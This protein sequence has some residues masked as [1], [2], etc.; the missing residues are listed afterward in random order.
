MEDEAKVRLL[1]SDTSPAPDQV[2]SGEEIAGFLELGE[3]VF[4]AAALA[5]RTIAGN[6]LQVLKRI[7]LMDLATDAPSVTKELRA[8]A[9]AYD[10]KSN[11]IIEAIAEEGDGSGFE[12]AE[13]VVDDF[14][15]REKLENKYL[16]EWMAHYA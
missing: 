6:E 13:V 4:G 10:A 1:I 9:D 7:K 14:Q 15:L 8:L 12:I 3:N 5:L 2:F 16:A 11:L